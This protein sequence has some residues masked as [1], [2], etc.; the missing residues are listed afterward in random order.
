MKA[1]KLGFKLVA[2]DRPLLNKYD[3]WRKQAE[4]LKLSKLSTEK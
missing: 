2:A 3:R 1:P 4:L